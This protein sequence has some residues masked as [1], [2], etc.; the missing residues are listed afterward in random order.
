MDEFVAGGNTITVKASEKVSQV[1][2]KQTLLKGGIENALEDESPKK[3]SNAV[4]EVPQKSENES[5]DKDSVD[6]KENNSETPDITITSNDI[7]NIGQDLEDQITNLLTVINNGDN[8]ENADT[9]KSSGD[10]DDIVDTSKNSGDNDNNADTSNSKE[11]MT[12]DASEINI[13]INKSTSCDET[14]KDNKVK[15][16]ETNSEPNENLNSNNTYDNQENE[17]EKLTLETDTGK[18]N[19]D[20]SEETKTENKFG[21]KDS[22]SYLKNSGRATPTR[23]SSRLASTPCTIKTRRASRLAQDNEQKQTPK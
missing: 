10:N 14:N 6:V 11:E 15:T 1:P 2:R 19:N 21:V 13:E 16:M 22:K 7:L 5:S 18:E 3:N 8:N 20:K 23:S 17:T 12:E 4:K 9:S